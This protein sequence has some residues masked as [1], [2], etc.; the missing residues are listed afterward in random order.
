MVDNPFDSYLEPVDASGREIDDIRESRTDLS[1]AL[2]RLEGTVMPE[3][4]PALE[5]LIDGF[6]NFAAKV[7]LIGQVKAGKT[8]LTN[9][10][11]GKSDLLP[12]DVNPWTSV[13]TSMHINCVAPKGKR[14][15]FRFFTSEDWDDL[16]SDG[17]R[18]VKLAKRARLDTRLDELTAQ[19]DEMRT[20]TET[21]LGR[22]FS[23]LLG[24]QH[25][26]SSFNGDLIK[27]YVC[28]GDEDALQDREGRFADMTKSADLYLE[29]SL[30]DYPLTIAD[31]PGVND[32]FLVREAATL[33]N[34]GQSD[35]CVV[36][37]S[38]NQALSSVDVGLIRLLKSLKSKRLIAF[39]N[40][41]DELSDPH[42][43]I[44]EIR[45]YISGVLKKQDLDD[46][47]PIIFGSAAWADAAIRGSYEDLPEDSIE[48]LA[49]LVE[50]R[51][52][53]PNAKTPDPDN[54]HGVADVS[55]VSALRAAIDR[56]VWDEVYR[57]KIA[58]S[59]N[60]ARRLAER[61][62]LYLT[63]ASNSVEV[64]M[65]PLRIEQSVKVLSAGREAIA[66]QLQ[67][68]RETTVE[69]VKLD[70]AEAYMR[71][72]Q[73]EKKNLLNC[74]SKTRRVVDWEP[75]TEGLR[76][77]LNLAYRR[78][79][80]DAISYFRA[81]TTNVVENVAKAYEA[82]LGSSEGIRITAPPIPEPPIP[83]SLM[84]TMSIDLRASSSLE[85]LRQR[86]DKSVYL[87]QFSSIAQDDLQQ[88]VSETCDDIVDGYIEATGNEIVA[89]L[90]EHKETISSFSKMNEKSI[91][92]RLASIKTDDLGLASRVQTLR[93]ASDVLH[94]L[95]GADLDDIMDGLPRI[96]AAE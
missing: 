71:F 76:G 73:S 31:T 70:L 58:K 10:L 34:L 14:A 88:T 27:R 32:P 96:E 52:G 38:A 37:L 85:W 2:Q 20:R 8:A 24:N 93:D 54:T 95:E 86:L 49:A 36:V 40:R 45:D 48:S 12:S 11:L 57:P 87:E 6:D 17:G 21:R 53:H 92:E 7:S 79:A 1:N 26:F 19:I 78:Y 82:T 75:D 56:R 25:S 23:M 68:Y 43:Q 5:E 69:K 66:A 61:S 84:R 62:M 9:A 50:A 42:N 15:I 51:S 64:K 60:R 65:D 41:I 80:T 33:D 29:S 47:V 28:L 81:V 63:E 90:D 59:A 72:I 55:G 74:I 94:A 39:V 13:V 67:D 18:I 22:N 77:S 16:V 35:I 4:V 91:E 44:A 30:F 3:D 83:V 46:D 89:F